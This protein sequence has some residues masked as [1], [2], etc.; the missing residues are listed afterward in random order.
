MQRIS[1]VYFFGFD[2]VESDVR[3]LTREFFQIVHDT[4]LSGVHPPFPCFEGVKDHILPFHSQELRANG[5]FKLVGRAIAYNILHGGPANEGL[6]T[7]VKTYLV[8]K[9]I[10]EAADTVSIDSCPYLYVVE[11]LK[12]T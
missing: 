7:L 8:T 10:D 5:I 1:V 3:G 12:S 9:S 2:E 11:L 4:I 6:A